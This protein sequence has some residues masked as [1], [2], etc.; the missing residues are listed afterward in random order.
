MP[1]WC[2]VVCCVVPCGAMRAALFCFVPLCFDRSAQRCRAS[3]VL[4]VYLLWL[5]P[6]P[7]LKY[8]GVA[9]RHVGQPMPG[10]CS[11]QHALHLL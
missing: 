5:G 6:G 10:N 8:A 9:F 7:Q 2:A 11:Y 4:C 1:M 3:I